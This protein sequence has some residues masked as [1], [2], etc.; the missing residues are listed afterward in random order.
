MEGTDARSPEWW[1]QL[2]LG[3]L[4][5]AM[6]DVCEGVWGM[7]TKL[8]ALDSENLCFSPGCNNNSLLLT[9]HMT[10][11]LHFFFFFSGKWNKHWYKLSW[12]KYYSF[13]K[14]ACNITSE[15]LEHDTKCKLLSF[16]LHVKY[17][18]TIFSCRLS[19]HNPPFLLTWMFH[20]NSVASIGPCKKERARVSEREKPTSAALPVSSPSW[21]RAFP[22]FC[23]QHCM[24]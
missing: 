8:A 12:G 19:P 9:L 24:L 6:R 14:N 16:N 5:A 22:I 4:R 17:P 23:Q 15:Y 20:C 21:T 10:L 7:E 3:R 1:R 11:W 2:Y 13:E 18:H